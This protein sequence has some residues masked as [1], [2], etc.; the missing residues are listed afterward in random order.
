MKIRIIVAGAVMGSIA[1]G[2]SA[3]TP[4]PSAVSSASAE[5][6]ITVDSLTPAEME[7]TIRTLKSNFVDPNALKNQ[8]IDRATLEGLLTRLRGGAMLLPSKTTNAESP[9]PFYS[10]VLGNHIGYVRIG[11]LSPDNLGALDKAISDFA[12]KKVDAMVLDLRATSSSDFNLAAETTKRFVPKGKT[13]WTLRKAGAH[14]DRTFSNDRDPVF[15]ETTIVLVDRETSGPA[16]GM[17]AAL[18]A[19]DQA[20]LIGQPTAGRAVEYSDFPLTSG[21]VLRVAVEEVIGPNGVSLFP[22]GVKP[23]LAV[24]LPLAQKHQIFSQSAQRGLTNFVFERERPHFNEAALIAGTNPEIEIRQ[25][26]R[27]PEESV[28][29]SVLQRAVDVITSL[30]IFQK[31]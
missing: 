11:S 22:D 17:A 28:H 16:E 8:E 26:R 13:L 5:P 19:H 21:K 23:D 27:G 25:Q 29:D 3:Q 14:Q 12:A 9:A 15:Q 1:S 6:K 30:A 24:E 2:I 4:G 20:L 10:E 7:E 31:H 18:K